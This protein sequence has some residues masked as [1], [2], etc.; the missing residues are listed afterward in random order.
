MTEP[1]QAAGALLWRPGED[2]PQVLVVHRPRY[3][4][5]TLPKGKLD[6][7]EHVTAAAV[8]E[9]FEETG[10]RIVLD[11]PL[12]T[13]RYEVEGLPKVVWF[14]AARADD[15]APEWNGTA[16]IA[17]TQFVS[18]AKADRLL[19][20]PRDVD[21]IEAFRAVAIAATLVVA[22]VIHRFVEV[23]VLQLKD[24]PLRNLGRGG[25]GS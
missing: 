21:V 10:H 18:A 22:A 3:D 1:I 23:P 9:V 2:G 20:Y 5:W 17:Q 19:S 24:R 15:G 13:L 8:R 14:W 11:R 4:D 6:P 12:P 7:G 25:A 16:E